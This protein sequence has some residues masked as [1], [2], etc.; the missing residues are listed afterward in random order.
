MQQLQ[1]LPLAL[2]AAVTACVD[3]PTTREASQSITAGFA[4]P[5]GVVWPS[6]TIRVCWTAGGEPMS[7]STAGSLAPELDGIEAII[8]AAWEP[9]VNVH[10]A[11]SRDC[12]A[13]YD[14][15]LDVRGNQSI[16]YGRDLHGIPPV[17]IDF[18]IQQE[19][20]AERHARLRDE[21]LLASGRILG[22]EW[23]VFDPSESCQS[24]FRRGCADQSPLL[25]SAV[26]A[27]TAL[28]GGASGVF[29]TPLG[30]CLQVARQSQSWKLHYLSVRDCGTPTPVW[31][32]RHALHTSSGVI[33]TVLSSTSLVTERSTPD[34]RYMWE[35]IS[36]GTLTS[37]GGRCLTLGEIPSYRSCENTGN[38]TPTLFVGGIW[39]FA[40]QLQTKC[41][42][43]TSATQLETVEC[44]TPEQ[45]WEWQSGGRL[46]NRKFDRCLTI[47]DGGGD[48]DAPLTLEPC[49]VGA[50]NQRWTF[51]GE[52]RTGIF[53]E[54]PGVWG[55]PPSAGELPVVLTKESDRYDVNGNRV[56]VR[57]R[58]W[59]YVH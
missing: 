54:S 15:A 2:L 23:F 43:A 31:W 18:A 13:D 16:S 28:Y 55:A 56:E 32:D 26:L 22:L 21:A 35:P 36:T 49:R 52:V 20:A 40:V 45:E 58:W 50:T 57:E 30:Q 48:E 11:F 51:S 24:P 34:F 42:R 8:H 38:Q 9:T 10:W 33:S 47:P 41:L 53:N 27:A 59:S 6:S 7:S 39:T 4:V 3:A 37:V 17:G 14:V 1:P 29:I 12:L 19:S 25:P 5:V 44:P 46:H